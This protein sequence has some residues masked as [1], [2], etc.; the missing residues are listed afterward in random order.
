MLDSG[1]GIDSGQSHRKK[2]KFPIFNMTL[3][4]R[5]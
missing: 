2:G 1:G 5:G 4:V 3:R